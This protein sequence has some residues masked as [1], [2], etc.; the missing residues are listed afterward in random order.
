MLFL[1][2]EEKNHYPDRAPWSPYWSDSFKSN[3][4]PYLERVSQKENLVICYGDSWTWGDSL[5]NAKAVHGV[6]DKEFR[7]NHIYASYL[8]NM[9]NA[10]FVNC[11]IPGVFNYWIHNRLEILLNHDI[12]RLSKQYNK[13]FIVV[14][15]TEPG[16]DFE[17]SLYVDEFAKFY[18]FKNS[19]TPADILV[20]AELFD[21]T[22]L[23][24]VQDR[25][26]NNCQLTIARNFTT[27]HNVNLNILDN[28]APMTWT[29]VLLTA[30]N[31]QPVNP[32][33]LVSFG[34]DKF[35]TFMCSHNL[36]SQDYKQWMLTEIIPK[37]SKQIDLL[38][39]SMYNYKS[40]SK[41]PTPE[42]HKMWAEYLNN[43]IKNQK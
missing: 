18:D 8:S 27:T 11:A 16:R 7:S 36:N 12:D 30:Q 33:V 41:H 3:V 40:E 17:F 15:L 24:Y 32:V 28:L 13:I 29:D 14:T 5:G 21:F 31:L 37:A 35:D 25:L 23:K 19:T 20:Q 22:K 34:T 9:L 39:K 1:T 6:D 38:H 43:F 42:G 26:P 10:D 4:D 2:H